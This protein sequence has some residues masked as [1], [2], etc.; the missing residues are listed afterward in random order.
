[1]M[2][3]LELQSTDISTEDLFDKIT[4]AGFKRISDFISLSWG[5][6][7]CETYIEGLIISNRT[8]RQGFPPEV[9]KAI[10][11]LYNVHAAVF[12]L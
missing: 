7:E 10:L 9:G 4:D 6:K 2:K 5:T 12:K 1:M 3:K 11:K 8:D